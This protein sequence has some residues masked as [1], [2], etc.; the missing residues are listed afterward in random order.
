MRIALFN[1]GFRPF[2]LAAPLFAVIAMLFWFGFF[3]P[4][5]PLPSYTRMPIAWH[6]HEMLFGYAVAV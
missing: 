2:F 6:A 1:L 3:L 4:D 5:W